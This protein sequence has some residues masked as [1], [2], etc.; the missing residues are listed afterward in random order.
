MSSDETWRAVGSNV[1]KTPV[2][3][4]ALHNPIRNGVGDLPDVRSTAV[5]TETAKRSNVVVTR[6][7]EGSESG[8]AKTV[9]RE[10]DTLI[11]PNPGNG[12]PEGN[13]SVTPRSNPVYLAS[14]VG[15]CHNSAGATTSRTS[16][17]AITT[18][19]V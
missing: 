2:P 6:W 7:T 8:L 1:A 14:T 19:S 12:N 5:A 18:S 16:I 15:R 11:A 10:G 3:D 13:D 4:R 17:A 9:T